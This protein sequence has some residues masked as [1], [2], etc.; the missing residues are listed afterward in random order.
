MAR[1]ITIS[2][3]GGRHVLT[4][5][6]VGSV[7]TYKGRIIGEGWHQRY[8][9]PHAERN[10]LGA[11]KAEDRHLL[12]RSHLYVTL[13]PCNHHGKTP[14][15]TDAILETRIPS[16]TIACVDPNPQMQGSSIQLLGQQG[17]DVRVGLLQ[18]EARDINRVFM[19]QQEYHRPYV[20]LKWAQ[21]SDR[22]IGR[23]GQQI[24]LT[25][26]LSK[27][28]VHK[29]RSEVDA[30]MIGTNTAIVDKPKLTT[31]LVKGPSPIRVVLDRSGR[32]RDMIQQL[33]PN[34]ET[35]IFTS[36]ESYPG[37]KH[38]EVQQVQPDQW[39]LEEILNRLYRRGISTLMV[40]GGG[41]LLDSFVKLGCWDE[42]RIFTTKH[43][44]RK[45]INA[46]ET[47][48][49]LR[50]KLTLHDDSLLIIRNL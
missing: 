33:P 7:I 4:N 45:G 20:I 31:R 6:L 30:I 48:G 11:V 44:L 37:A 8:G 16:V 10:A 46:P 23:E 15:C 47:R 35:L 26:E 9:E 50:Q 14:P 43:E 2:A 5:P 36:C 19:V 17:V 18:D 32:L 39:T 13:E 49:S 24:W 27:T 42:A 21:S 38:I 25:N 1:A 28:V 29:W 12:P 34:T 40:E 41:K 22:Y 3:Y